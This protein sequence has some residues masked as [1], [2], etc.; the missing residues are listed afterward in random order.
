MK[1][2]LVSIGI[3]ILMFI[4]VATPPAQAAKNLGYMFP[5]PGYSNI[6]Q[7]YNGS[8]HPAIDIAAVEG[9]P[10]YAIKDGTINKVYE[11]CNNKGGA[12]A[13]GISCVARGI[14]NP[15]YGYY[16]NYC[17]YGSGNGVVIRH[18]GNIWSEYSH[19]IAVADGIQEGMWVKQGT[20]I[21]YVGDA[22]FSAGN[23][24]HFAM[25]SGS[26]SNYWSNSPINPLNYMDTDDTGNITLPGAPSGLTASASENKVTVKWNSVSNATSYECG[27]RNLNTHE[28]IVKA[29]VTGTSHTFSGIAEGSYWAYVNAINA[30][31]AGP[32]PE[33]YKVTVKYATPSDPII[34][35]SSVNNFEGNNVKI[36][37]NA[38]SNASYYN[39]YIAEYPEG[40]AYTTSTKK[41]NTK[42]TSITF[43]D[44]KSGKYSVFI[45]AVTAMGKWSGQ[46]NWQTFYVYAKDYIPTKTVVKDDHIYALYDYEM[47]WTFARDLCNDL[48][49][50][51]V[52]ITSA[53][54]NQLITELVQSGSKD[55]YWLGATDMDG[56]EKDFKWVTG[57]EFVY[58]NWLAGEP[59]SAGE[60]GTKE[61]FMEFRKSYGNKWNDVH[62][63]KSDNKGFIL[64]VDI[65]ELSPTATE[66]YNGNQYLLFDKN[67]TWTE[68]EVICE[69]MGGHLVTLDSA[70]ENEFIQEFINSGEREWYY[71]GGQKENEVWKWNDGRTA[72]Y[73]TWASNASAWTG[74]NLMMYKSNGTCI[75][76]DN[77]YFPEPDISR[78]GFVCELEGESEF[79]IDVNIEAGTS[80]SGINL[81]NTT[82]VRL[83]NLK[84]YD[85]DA[86]IIYVYKYADGSIG[87][88][89]VQPIT[90]AAKTDTNTE[91]TVSRRITELNDNIIDAVE[92]YVWDSV[93]SMQPLTK[94]TAASF[95]YEE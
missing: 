8:G 33:W 53:E 65:S 47:S 66:S 19:M 64:E 40:Y 13:G 81:L 45:H 32:W 1:K 38:V 31:G 60:K 26:N 6:S 20:L 16:E 85:I 30:A 11:G 86:E 9:T 91:N 49:G 2:R 63:T 28:V 55:A 14:C 78:L 18:D 10:I 83:T 17:N 25:K 44:L 95:T 88:T 80:V 52:T 59:N 21:G 67:T 92:V 93:D 61:Q 68:A 58:D 77:A 71:L 24:C 34:K 76:I 50:H 72:N 22:G 79:P 57:E 56:Q 73:I 37:W 69:Q 15:V 48:G 41:G 70:G 46:S 27:L 89:N 84:S 82:K 75:G 23:H 43:N 35:V 74:A 87:E 54:E 36:S 29:N 3:M 39:Y 12:G 94:N 7:Y 51:L 62:N 5:I 4:G 90:L 42:S